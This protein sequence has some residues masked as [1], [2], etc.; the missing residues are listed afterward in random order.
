MNNINPYDTP[1]SEL[2]ESKLTEFSE[3]PFWGVSGRIGRIRYLAYGMIMCFGFYIAATIVSVI[4]ITAFGGFASIFGNSSDVGAG[5]GVGFAIMMVISLGFYLAIFIYFIL[6][7][8]RRL[9]D[10]DWSGW[11]VLLI[12]VPIINVVMALILLFVPGTKGE[13]R[14]GKQTPPNGI[15]MIL[16]AIVPF[17]LMLGIIVAIAIPA[18]HDYTQRVQQQM[19]MHEE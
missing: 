7:W 8:I 14:F 2:N 13:N 9:H 10:I 16:L 3:V 4:G 11:T 18:Y 19:Q 5:I 1:D 6:L 17:V 15:G 12:F